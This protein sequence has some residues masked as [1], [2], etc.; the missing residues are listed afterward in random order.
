MFLFV[1]SVFVDFVLFLIK[2]KV[3]AHT[4]ALHT[5]LLLKWTKFSRHLL[6]LMLAYSWI[7]LVVNICFIGVFRFYQ[8]NLNELLNYT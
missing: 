8:E 6:T 7:E 5:V 4:Q 2:K 1:I 3:L